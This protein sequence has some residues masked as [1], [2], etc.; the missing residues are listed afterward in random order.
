MA[1]GRRTS[2]CVIKNAAKPLK[3]RA[4]AQ[5]GALA[6]AART[7]NAAL[8]QVK[9]AGEGGS[10]RSVLQRVPALVLKLA[11]ISDRVLVTY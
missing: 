1:A 9:A 11:M 10:A 8:P 7:C 2:R 5:A 6:H 3:I 4:R